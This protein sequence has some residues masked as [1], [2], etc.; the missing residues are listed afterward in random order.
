M[1]YR[2]TQQER[3][4]SKI[5]IDKLFSQ[6]KGFVKYP[7]KIQYLAIDQPIHAVVFSVPKRNFKRAVDRNRI[8]RLMRETYRLN[9]S[10][11]LQNDLPMQAIFFIYIA[12]DMPSYDL[13][14]RR[15]KISLKELK[16]R[17]A[18]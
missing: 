6:G 16:K 7:F 3:L 10:L 17:V 4:K 13:I 14:E 5:I 1:K 18:N 12:K 8:K 11:I 15:M 9:K 2:F